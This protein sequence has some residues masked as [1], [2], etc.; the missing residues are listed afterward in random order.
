MANKYLND[1][2]KLPSEDMERKIPGA[3]HEMEKCG[4][5]F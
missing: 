1:G 2:S 5:I 4:V 3:L